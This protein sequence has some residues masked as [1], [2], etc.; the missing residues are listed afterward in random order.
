M[1]DDTNNPPTSVDSQA[2]EQEQPIQQSTGV[3]DSQAQILSEQLIAVQS[4]IE[5]LLNRSDMLQ[6]KIKEIS[7]S[8]RSILE[9]DE[10]LQIAQKEAEKATQAT[11]ER[12]NNLTQGSEYK[13]LSA[14]LKE[15]KEE[16][17]EIQESLNT[18][19]LTYY[20]QTG[21]KTLDL[22]SGEREF[23]LIAKVKPKRTPTFSA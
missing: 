8:M 20:T 9:N 18:H 11:K 19:L 4:L 2:S 6:A 5:R 23:S 16:L 22:Q 10:A 1:Q 7:D 17:K 21:V 12:R 15:I 3:D 13:Q 14:H